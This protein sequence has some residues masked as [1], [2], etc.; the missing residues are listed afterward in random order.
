MGTRATPTV[1]LPRASSPWGLSLDSLPWG[2]RVRSQEDRA[3]PTPVLSR[4]G[5]CS[6]PWLGSRAAT[7]RGD[8]SGPHG[9]DCCSLTPPRLQGSAGPLACPSPHLLNLQFSQ[10][11]PLNK[12]GAPLPL[13]SSLSLGTSVTS[14]RKP[15]WIPW[16]SH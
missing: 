4:G 12:P 7:T 14:C 13:A 10:V 2:S 15:P 9:S 5:P 8:S 1:L 11:L 16:C 3:A 6:G